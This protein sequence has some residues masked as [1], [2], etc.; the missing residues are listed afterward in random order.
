MQRS[1]WMSGSRRLIVGRR[2]LLSILEQFR[3]RSTGQSGRRRRGA[4][5]PSTIREGFCAGAHC[6]VTERDGITQEKRN[7]WGEVSEMKWVDLGLAITRVF[8]WLQPFWLELLS[9]LG[10]RAVLGSAGRRGANPCSSGRGG[11]PTV[12]WIARPPGD[13]PSLPAL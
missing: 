8:F 6:N 13:L 12:A 1:L 5:S 4:Q 10:S 11:T 2:A 3:F 7:R 9:V